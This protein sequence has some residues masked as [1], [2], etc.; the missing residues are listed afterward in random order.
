MNGNQTALVWGGNESTYVTGLVLP[1]LARATAAGLGITPTT[2]VESTNAA[3]DGRSYVDIIQDAADAFI[4]GQ[5]TQGNA[6]IPGFRGGWRYTPST[7]QSDGSTAQWGAIGLTFAQSGP[8]VVVPQYVKDELRFWIDYIQCS[9]NGG[10][11]YDQPCGGSAPVTPS[12]TGGLLASMAFAG[13][14]GTKPGDT[15][16]RTQ[17]LNYL[18]SNWTATADS[19]WEGNFGHP[20]AMW[21][22][23][24]GLESEIGLTGTAI[25]NFMYGVAAQVKDNASDPWNW[26]EDYSQYLVNS[27]NAASGY[28]NGYSYW[29]RQLSTAWA[30]NILNATQ[31]GDH[32]A[33]E[34]GTLALI[35]LGLAAATAAGR[36]RKAL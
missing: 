21:S 26:W 5:T 12:K 13:Y 11:G 31:I 7:G 15:L 4:W 3:V 29:G 8:G 27:Q 17:A 25:D 2:K 34:P 30:I 18:N 16:G 9:T 35:G 33:P 19:T 10:A 36:R 28:W 14:D 23:Y 32:K 6:A 1:A 24:K 22:V 20:Y